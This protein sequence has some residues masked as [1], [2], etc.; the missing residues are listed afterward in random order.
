MFA[1]HL[2][3]E[4]EPIV[5][6][7]CCKWFISFLWTFSLLNCLCWCRWPAFYTLK[8]INWV[9]LCVYDVN[10]DWRQ[11]SL[12]YYYYSFEQLSDPSLLLFCSLSSTTTRSDRI[13]PLIS[14]L[15]NFISLA[16]FISRKIFQ[17]RPRNNFFQSICVHKSLETSW[18]AFFFSYFFFRFAFSR[19]LRLAIRQWIDSGSPHA[20]YSGKK[21][22]GEKTKKK[23]V[24]K[25]QGGEKSGTKLNRAVDG[26]AAA[27]TG[28]FRNE[29]T[30][31][32]C[33]NN[34][35]INLN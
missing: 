8:R 34:V 18:L 33:Q 10:G 27:K 13:R 35:E 22:E 11:Y 19:L 1:H 29:L 16:I 32:K 24:I 26:W 2:P 30:E 6:F 12:N 23:V 5:N 15:M 4:N 7:I 31:E 21:I 9:D 17:I 20:A 3:S 25:Y 28:A 14:R